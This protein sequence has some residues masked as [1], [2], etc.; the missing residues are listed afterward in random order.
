MT[1]TLTVVRSQGSVCTLAPP[2][3]QL[4][5]TQA[6]QWL[7]ELTKDKTLVD[8]PHFTQAA[9]VVLNLTKVEHMDSI[10]IKAIMALNELCKQHAKPM[11]IEVPV[12]PVTRLLHHCRIDQLIPV[13]EAE[14]SR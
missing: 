13:R 12:H 5:A 7:N 11:V 9:G 10:A 2:Y 3:A 8:N 1:Q 4:V 6:H 14:L